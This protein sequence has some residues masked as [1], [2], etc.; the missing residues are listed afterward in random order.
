M[1][2]SNYSMI[3]FFEAHNPV[4]N[5]FINSGDLNE[6]KS[7]PNHV[8][9]DFIN[10]IREVQPKE[11]QPPRPLDFPQPHSVL[12]PVYDFSFVQTEKKSLFSSQPIINTSHSPPNQLSAFKT[13]KPSNNEQTENGL[14]HRSWTFSN[15]MME[16]CNRRN[17]VET[18][19]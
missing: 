13:I 12:F 9:S 2:N 10:N 6:I 5:S 4:N 19:R 17:A 8:F 18:K 3:N 7:P 14:L 15:D 11:E 16:Q 1:C